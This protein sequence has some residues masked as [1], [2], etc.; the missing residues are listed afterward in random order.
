VGGY[1]GAK[2]G[3]YQEVI[4]RYLSEFNP[5]VLAALNTRYVI[6]GGEAMPTASVTGVEPYGAAWFVSGV[7]RRATAR[8]E[9]EALGS[10]ALDSVA[11]V[12]ESV[13]GLEAEYDASGV[14]ELVEYAPNRLKYE[15]EAPSEALCLFSEIYFPEGWSVTIDGRE[16]DYFAADY[17]LRGMELPAGKHTVEWSFRAPAWR[18]TSAVMGIAS[19]L[20]LAGCVAVAVLAILNNR[21]R[22]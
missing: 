14:I 6:Y 16:A 17:I 7:E 8:E 15:Y 21:K 18:A 13:K 9:L 5:E 2:L 22:R 1:H 12:A 11:V 4:D 20:I 10:V 19:A 3:R